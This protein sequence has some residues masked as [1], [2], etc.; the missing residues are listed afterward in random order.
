MSDVPQPQ[1]QPATEP[2]FAPY[3]GPSLET[4]K[5]IVASQFQVK[6]AFLDPYGIPTIL[7]SAEP[8]REKFRNVVE[9]LRTQNLLGAIRV[10]G[11]TLTIKVFQKPQIKPSRRTINLGLFLAT[12]VTVTVAGYFLWTGGLGGSETL[13][14]QCCHNLPQ[15]GRHLSIF[16][17]GAASH[18]HLRS[19][20]L[21]K[22]STCE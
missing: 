2:V 22:G 14:A 20:H 12:V 3:T 6:D 19:P 1:P 15:A 7:V 4:V 9:Q 5:S 16:H 13:Q 17:P 8:T 10:T 11:D 21:S 18:R